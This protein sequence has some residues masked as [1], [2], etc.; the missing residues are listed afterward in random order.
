MDKNGQR[1]PGFPSSEDKMQLPSSPRHCAWFT[2][3]L[4]D[5]QTCQA[6]TENRKDTHLAKEGREEVTRLALSHLYCNF[7]RNA[8]NG[9][10]RR[11]EPAFLQVFI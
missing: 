6:S 4:A 5:E 9:I 11:I 1:I 3:V 2:Q 7:Q 10:Q 8:S